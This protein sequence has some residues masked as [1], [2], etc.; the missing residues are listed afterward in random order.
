MLLAPDLSFRGTFHSF[1]TAEE[2]IASLRSDPPEI[3]QFSAMNIIDDSDSVALFYEY[4]K[5]GLVIQIA[6]LFR[7]SYQQINE[8]L[9]VFDGRNI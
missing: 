1:E 8:I 6:Q 7:T 5:C 4:Q 2:Y 9:L 3:C